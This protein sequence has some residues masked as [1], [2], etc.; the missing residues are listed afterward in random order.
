MMEEDIQL[1]YRTT[2]LFYNLG[3]F[4]RRRVPLKSYFFPEKSD[5]TDIDVYGIKWDLDLA[6]KVVVGMCTTTK[7]KKHMDPANRILWL[8]G[9]K[10]FLGVSQ[11]YLVMPRITPKF[12]TFAA[13]NGVIPLDY[14]RFN[15]LEKQ[16]NISDWQGF[17]ALDN[18]ARHVEYW[19][20]VEKERKSEIKQHYCCL[21]YTSPSPRD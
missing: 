5:I 17:Y 16:L 4:A 10:D 1:E 13:I 20:A 19:H 2:R 8:R 14:E 12:K 9:L 18:F 7:S 21:L 11:T 6:P 15:E 3:Y